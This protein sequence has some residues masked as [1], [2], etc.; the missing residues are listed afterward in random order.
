MVIISV[1]PSLSLARSLAI[2][3]DCRRGRELG[4]F[5]LR[6]PGSTQRGWGLQRIRPDPHQNLES[7]RCPPALTR[8]SRKPY[9]FRFPFASTLTLLLVEFIGSFD[10]ESIRF[11]F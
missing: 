4:G 7:I 11:R 1:R 3:S 2:T 8:T 6:L 5:L 10:S 9:S